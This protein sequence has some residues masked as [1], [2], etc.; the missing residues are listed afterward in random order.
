[1]ERIGSRGRQGMMRVDLIGEDRTLGERRQE[2]RSTGMEAD[3]PAGGKG[4]G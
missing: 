1:M 2:T 3:A 4:G